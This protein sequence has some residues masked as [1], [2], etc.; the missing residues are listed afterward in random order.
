MHLLSAAG[1]RCPL[2]KQ[3]LSVRI[4]DREKYGKTN[5]ESCEY[6]DRILHFTQGEQKMVK[7]MDSGNSLKMNVLDSK[8]PLTYLLVSFNS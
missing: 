5:P 4:K 6:T 2:V 7:S 1:V 8:I 3:F